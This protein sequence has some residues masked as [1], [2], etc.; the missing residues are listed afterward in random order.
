MT[1]NYDDRKFVLLAI[2]LLIAVVYIFRLFYIQV[3]DNSYTLS[4]RNQTLQYLTQYPARG[5]VYDRNGEL[6]V[7]NEAAY[8]L[9]VVPREV[10]NIDTLAFCALLGITPDDFKDRFQKAKEYSRYK[11][12]IFEKMLT[13]EEFAAISGKLY[14]YPG[15][16]G[17]QRTLRKYPQKTAASVLGYIGEVDNQITSR[18]PYYKTGDYIGVSGLEKFYEEELRGQR[19]L[20]IVVKDVHNRIK[21]SF[22][23]GQ[24]DTLA[25]PGL[26]LYSSLDID[27]QQYGERLMQHKKGSIVAIEPAT[28]EILC[29]VSS[30]SYDPNLLVGRDRAKNYMALLNNDSLVPLFNRALMASYPPGSTFKLVQSL[31]GLQEKVISENTGFACN[32]ALVGCH[33]HPNA[34]TLQQGI[35]MSCNPYFFNVFKRIINQN[36]ASS[37][38]KDSEIGLDIWQKHML[39]F[40]LGKPLALDLPDMKGGRVPGVKYYDKI[41][42]HGRW[43]FS[44]IYS[45]SI[46]QGE[47]EITPVQ[48]ANLSAII[49]NRGFYYT[50]H[51]VRSIGEKEGKKRPEYE[52]RN[53]TTVDSAYFNIITEGMRRVVQE[54]GGTAR[55]ARIDSVI[56]CGKTGTVETTSGRDHSVFMAFAPMDNPKIAISVYTEN[57][58]FGGAVS[59]PIASLMMEKYLKGSVKDTLK[60][61]TVL[62]ADFIKDPGKPKVKVKR[63]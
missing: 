20:K 18:N 39:S 14:L 53:F 60:E 41:Y 10:K 58:G 9:M 45:L 11:A 6:L 19:G 15:F 29:L 7:F 27:L 23:K 57:A 49:A 1:K 2:F 48:L 63:R 43:A 52:K 47:V 13:A 3:I 24:Y 30:P 46:G 50:P 26:D 55:Q 25:I 22:R 44:T 4:A 5:L 8:D 32:K 33:N 12:S 34:V 42:G 36:K 21:E 54:S 16:F 35:Q 37:N 28:G 61:R 51:L 56:V 17:Q 38:F 59:A 62:E 40:G 31:V